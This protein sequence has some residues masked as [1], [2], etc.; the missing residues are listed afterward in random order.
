ML[1]T[2]L[3]LGKYEEA[4][5]D[6]TFLIGDAVATLPSCLIRIAILE[7]LVNTIFGDHA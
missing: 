3:K 7:S 2:S 4:S 1:H 6:I 5:Y